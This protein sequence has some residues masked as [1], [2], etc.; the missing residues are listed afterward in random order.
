M[1]KSNTDNPVMHTA[2]VE[3]NKASRKLM[4]TPCV[5]LGNRRR[6]VPSK[7]RKRKLNT[8][9]MVGLK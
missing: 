8:K 4:F 3:V 1:A 9:R 2:L 7:I 6:N 5:A